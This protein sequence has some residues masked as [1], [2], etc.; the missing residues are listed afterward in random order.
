M[1]KKLI[2]TSEDTPTIRD[3]KLLMQ[4]LLEVKNACS[5]LWGA[6]NVMD[7]RL[8]QVF[9][10]EKKQHEAGKKFLN[11]LALLSD[12]KKQ[13][14]PADIEGQKQVGKYRQKLNPTDKLVLKELSRGHFVAMPTIA[15]SIG[16]GRLSV[17]ESIKVLRNLNYNVI[18]KNVSGSGRRYRKIYKIEGKKENA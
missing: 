1:N 4:S 15:G 12:D 2:P 9:K 16:R 14:I 10:N 3:Y 11:E 13:D 5:S 6:V 18:T 17:A 8:E 7:A